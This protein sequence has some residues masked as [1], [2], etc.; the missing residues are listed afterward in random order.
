MIITKRML[1]HFQS[2][3]GRNNETDRNW[4]ALRRYQPNGPLVNS[5][6]YPGWLTH[7]QENLSQ[8]ETKPVVDTFMFVFIFCFLLDGIELNH[9]KLQWA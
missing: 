7:W 4:Q 6:Y 8:V 2:S 1:A 5:E 9:D 3:S